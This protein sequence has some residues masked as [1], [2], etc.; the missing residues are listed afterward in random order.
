[1]SIS[2]ITKVSIGLKLRQLGDV[3]N[4][5]FTKSVNGSGSGCGSSALGHVDEDG[6]EP[7]DSDDGARP[8]VDTW[9]SDYHLFHD[10][11]IKKNL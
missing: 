1:M 4:A 8:V 9:S 10:L 11:S 5:R 3:E 6:R 2:V 7:A